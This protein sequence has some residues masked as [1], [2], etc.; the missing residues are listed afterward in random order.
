MNRITALSACLLTAFLLTACSSP[1]IQRKDGS[2]SVRSFSLRNL[3]KSD[4]DTVIE[5]HQQAALASL[6]TL[7]LKLYRRNP[8]E[9]RKSGY[10][11]ADEAAEAVFKPLSHWYL[12]PQRNLDWK[13]SLRDAW[14]EDYTGDRV[15]ALMNGL[16]VMHMAAFNHRTEFYVLSDV[17]AQKL[18]NAARNTEAVVWRW[19]ESS[20]TRATARF[21]LV[22]S[23]SP[24][25]HF[26][27]SD[28]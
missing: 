25:W 23:I 6:K 3:A 27:R 8:G 14:R 22:S 4:V 19:P 10:T 9:W 11:Q 1:A 2:S 7:T 15:K 12:S 13:S 17:D 21:A 28:T 18:Y 20:R 24:A 5:I 26:C 16:L